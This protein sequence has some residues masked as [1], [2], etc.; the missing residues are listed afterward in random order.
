M[1][2]AP[3]HFANAGSDVDEP[4]GVDM[5]STATPNKLGK[6]L[7]LSSSICVAGLG[8]SIAW[9]DSS[10]GWWPLP[11][12][13][14]GGLAAYLVWQSLRWADEW[15][16]YLSFGAA[17]L[18]ACIA[19]R[20][21]YG[22]DLWLSGDRIAEWPFY[23]ARCEDAFRKAEAVTM[24]GTL[25]T[26]FSWIYFGGADRSPG[27]I[28]QAPP[29]KVVRVL[30]M[31]YALSLIGI[32]L[33]QA[34]PNLARGTGQLVPTMLGLGLAASFY[35]PL[36]IVRN[37]AWRLAVVSGMTLPFAYVALGTGMKEAVILALL[38]AGYQLW[39]H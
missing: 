38:P 14:T 36:M 34:L 1:S 30:T 25:L 7:L 26:V 24:L 13:V 19:N 22:A 39:T 15:T 28:A 17:L 33:T 12:F 23:A 37:P 35:L 29:A 27:S 2:R 5:N 20:I 6:L 3:R 11:L 9:G 21:L 31:T 10:G 18:L 32:V 16:K 4:G 8:L